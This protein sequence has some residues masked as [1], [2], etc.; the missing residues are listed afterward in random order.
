MK[1]F[2][3]SVL[4][5]AA[6]LTNANEAAAQVAPQLGA[7]VEFRDAIAITPTGPRPR[8]AGY[9]T[10]VPPG[11]LAQK[12]GLRVGD[13]LLTVN[14]FEVK[15]LDE[16]QVAAA[17]GHGN[18][19]LSVRGRDGK[20]RAVTYTAPPPP[21]IPIGGGAGG[22]KFGLALRQIPEGMEV[23]GFGPPYP[24]TNPAVQIGDVLHSVAVGGT[25][26][27]A[28]THHQLG[29][30]KSYL[31]PGRVAILKLTRP[32]FGFVYPV[33]RCQ[34]TGPGGTY[35]FEIDVSSIASQ[36]QFETLEAMLKS[37]VLP[38]SGVVVY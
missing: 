34:P 5:L 13:E 26:L 7:A 18:L 19:T 9:I 28:G 25:I 8:F 4:L 1:W 16:Y 29:M 31:G 24:P 37:S 11:S 2:L 27:P 23:T 33:V 15:S 30:A 14:N 20:V 6:V 21:V 38:G 22:L 17:S 3:S 12:I 32:G 36:T 10:D 35:Q